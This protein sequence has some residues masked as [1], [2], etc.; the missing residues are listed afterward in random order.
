MKT[1][2]LVF[3]F[4]LSCVA[5]GQQISKQ[6]TSSGGRLIGFLEY[7]PTDYQPTDKTKKYPLIIFLHG[8]GERGN[9]TT[10]LSRVA[11]NGIPK[12]IK[13]GHPM[14]FTWNG[15][16]ET[17]LVLSPQLSTDF[18]SWQD[19][20]VDEMIK[21]AKSNLNIDTNRV[22]LTGLS[23]GGGGV[24]HY[25]A[26]KLTNTQK[27]AAIGISC[28]T[29]QLSD[30]GLIADDDLPTWA[31]HAIDDAVVPVSN[32]YT[33]IQNINNHKPAVAPYQTIWAT[34]GH[35]IWDRVFD[36]A[37][38][39]QNPNIYEWFLAQNK[40]YKA[41]IRPVAYGGK[42]LTTLTATGSSVLNASGSR[43]FDGSIVRY[44]WRQLTGPK[45][46]ALSSPVSKDGLCPV[47]GATIA[48][49]YTYEVKVIDNRADYKSDTIVLTAISNE[50][51]VSVT[52]LSQSITLPISTVAVDGRG[53]YD[54]DGDIITYKWTQVSGPSPAMIENPDSAYT[55]IT[56]L[57][58]GEYSFRLTV[59]D[60][61]N[62]ASGSSL[63]VTVIP[64]PNIRPTAKAGNDD[65][66][67][68][69]VSTL[70]LD[71]SQ[72]YDRDGR[73][74]QY[75]WV[76]LL[77]PSS[78]TI[79]SPTAA[80]TNISNLVEGSYKFR[81]IV[82]DDRG[83]SAMDNHYVIVKA[84]ANNTLASQ[85]SLNAI[86]FRNN[87]PTGLFPNP[88]SAF[89]MLEYYS[90]VQGRA[91]IMLHNATGQLA[92]ANTAIATAGSNNYKLNLST[93]QKGIY[94]VSV[95]CNNGKPV[96]HRLVVQ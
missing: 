63:T 86:E 51:P 65:T 13:Y 50:L 4:M 79:E 15:K 6:L 61:L 25:A 48:G 49:T 14:R 35:S 71:G 91:T 30:Y 34:G 56:G 7:K 67:N 94:I 82:F 29:K 10:D 72:S 43:D 93:L 20:Y 78:F 85:K 53:S 75:K 47:S 52:G 1:N 69:P 36:T 62:S 22:I 18:G 21:Y 73:I 37:Y 28:G 32:T 77:G 41:N 33:I 5:K 31:F 88:A 80:T 81:L 24:W 96:V 89:T 8:I 95:S 83:D 23:L 12:Y 57:L 70:V 54:P 58:E 68:A 76:K 66:L 19:L 87:T 11:T 74:V 46:T 26:A 16:T 64:P 2:L 39:S 59:T 38:K 40:S 84:A 27:L 55:S 60:N 44:V 45:S 3:L 42:D 92:Q 90:D 17:F 9:G